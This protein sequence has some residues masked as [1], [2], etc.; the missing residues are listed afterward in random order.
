MDINPVF[1]FLDGFFIII[2]II[3][4]IITII[5]NVTLN[6]VLEYTIRQVI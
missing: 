6:M 1:P 5:F 4:I 3:I 2:I